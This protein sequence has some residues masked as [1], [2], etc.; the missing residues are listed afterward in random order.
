[1][2]IEGM[3]SGRRPKDPALTESI[4]NHQTENLRRA[5]ESGDP[6]KIFHREEEMAADFQGLRDVSAI[7]AQ[8]SSTRNT[9]EV[10]DALKREKKR[11]ARIDELESNFYGAYR[12]VLAAIFAPGAGDYERRQAIAGLRLPDL[13]RSKKDKADTEEGIAAERILSGVMIHSIEDGAEFR[14]R[15]DSAHVLVDMQIASECAP[16]NGYVLFRLARAYALNKDAKNALAT[17][18]QSIAKGFDDLDALE[19]DPDLAPLHSQPEFQDAVA[20]LKKKL[21]APSTPAN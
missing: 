19:N 3:K 5:R 18:G 4:Y 2:E 14:A 17:L 11:E 15:G 8:I 21:A 7:E 1:M 10:K 9:R 12:R 16:E 20:S 13:L 6:A